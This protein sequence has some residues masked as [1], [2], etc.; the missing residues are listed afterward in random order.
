MKNKIEQIKHVSNSNN[1]IEKIKDYCR[2]INLCY[3][4]FPEARSVKELQDNILS[5]FKQGRGEVT[6][7][8]IHKAK[9]I[10][11]NRVFLLLSDQMPFSWENMRDWEK[12][13]ELNLT[14]VA[15]TRAKKVLFLVNTPK[16]LLESLH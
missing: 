4:G 16:N 11:S 1:Q 8:T 9:G 12:E 10:E 2:G 3:E 14:Y 6:L 13:Q 5:L 7:S 15:L